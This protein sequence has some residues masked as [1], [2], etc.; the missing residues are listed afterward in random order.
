[1]DF[2][3]WKREEHIKTPQYFSSRAA[4]TEMHYV[5]VL[6]ETWEKFIEKRNKDVRS[7]RSKNYYIDENMK[8]K[9]SERFQEPSEDEMDIYYESKDYR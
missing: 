4:G 3:F 1:L 6:Q 2:G 8:R 5:D 7:G 9:F